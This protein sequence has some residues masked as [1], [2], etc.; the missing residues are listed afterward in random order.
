LF[1]QIGFKIYTKTPY[2]FLDEL[3]RGRNLS[4]SFYNSVA[5][6][7]DFS[8]TLV[9]MVEFTPEEIFAGCLVALKKSRNMENKKILGLM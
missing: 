4:L 5:A 3:V 6:F 2:D 9:E 7:L 1:S 8:L